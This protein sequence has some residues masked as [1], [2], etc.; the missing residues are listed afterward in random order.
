LIYSVLSL[1]LFCQ[2]ARTYLTPRKSTVGR[3]PHGQLAPRRQPEVVVEEEPEEVQPE[4][5]IE[6][7]PE[8]V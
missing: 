6:E 8:E 2:M 7:D 3:F 4:A 1:A 5:G